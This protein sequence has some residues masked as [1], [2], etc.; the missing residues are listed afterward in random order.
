[1]KYFKLLILLSVLTNS[2]LLAFED[3]DLDG[4]EDVLDDCPNTLIT[5]LVD[6]N[7]CTIKSL[8]TPHHFDIIIGESYAQEDDIDIYATNLQIDYYYKQFSFQVSTSYSSEDNT[9]YL[10]AYYNFNPIQNLKIRVGAGLIIETDFIAS[11]SISY[12]LDKLNIFGGYNLTTVEDDKNIKYQDIN[13]FNIGLGFYPMKKLYSSFS[14]NN[15]TSKYKDVENIENIS[16]YNFY[17]IDDNWFITLS[18]E[19]GVSES[20]NDYGEGFKVGYYF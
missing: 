8:S 10:V 16:L 12:S 9:N 7:G 18:F 14:Y 11:T 1:M 19:Y 3:F 6:I 15:S 2:H 13:S 5:D 4:V 20:A 17:S